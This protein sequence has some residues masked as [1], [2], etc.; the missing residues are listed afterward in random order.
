[1]QAAY[2]IRPC[3]LDD[4][5]I[6][7]HHRMSMFA[8]M[9]QVPAATLAKQLRDDSEA[10]LRAALHD[11]SYVGWLALGDED[12]II[13]GAG[14]TLLPMLPR[15]TADGARV[16]ASRVPLVVNVYTEPA[17]R[18][19]GIARALMQTVMDWAGDQGLDRVVLHASDA[20]RP[21]YVALGFAPTNEMR[22]NPKPR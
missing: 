22:W 21:M 4:A 20:G 2:R 3:V 13:A 12:R 18:Q 10:A 11:G 5:P 1:M 9:G 6:I 17:H 16:A 8:E 19:R 7:A 14:A 15:M